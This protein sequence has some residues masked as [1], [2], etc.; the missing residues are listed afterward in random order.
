MAHGT[1]T[2]LTVIGRVIA[3]AVSSI[4]FYLAFFLYENE[5]GIWQNRVEDLWVKVHERAQ[6]TDNFFLALFN[7]VGGTI[8]TLCNVIFGQRRISIQ[9]IATSTNLSLLGCVMTMLLQDMIGVPSLVDWREYAV[10]LSASLLLAGFAILAIRCRRRWISLA[11]LLPVILVIVGSLR[12]GVH[13]MHARHHF[14]AN[15]AGFALGLPV[16]LFFSLACDVLAVSILRRMFSTLSVTLSLRQML[17]IAA[18]LIAMIAM[19]VPV[20]TLIVHA[21]AT[22]LYGQHLPFN[23]TPSSSLFRDTI[24]WLLE[25]GRHWIFSLN[26]TTV[27]YCV[28]PLLIVVLMVLNKVIWPLV[29]RLT[30]SVA[31]N[32]FLLNRRAMV[33]IGCL[34]LTIALNLGHVGIKEILKLIQ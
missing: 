18:I 31:R 13:S 14:S 29:S 7:T 25:T 30:Y 26:V 28:I 20:P 8:T 17:G 33:Y 24:Y 19:L 2:V 1:I 32:R 3:F 23:D 10:F 16:F 4:C 11:A 15:N 6:I 21:I 12:A 22:G 34:T 9:M 5:D 27:I